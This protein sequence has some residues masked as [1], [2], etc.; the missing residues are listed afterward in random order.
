MLKM[1][2]KKTRKTIEKARKNLY[3]D[4]IVKQDR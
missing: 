4:N 2:I 3:Y 1:F